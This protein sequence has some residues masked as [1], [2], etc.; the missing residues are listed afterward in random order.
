MT[1]IQLTFTTTVSGKCFTDRVEVEPR[2]L[3]WM[4]RTWSDFGWHLTGYVYLALRGCTI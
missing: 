4:I 1:I 3:D 2:E